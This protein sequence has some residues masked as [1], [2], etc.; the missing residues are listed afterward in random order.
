MTRDG[1]R[2]INLTPRDCFPCAMCGTE[3][4]HRYAVPWYE[5][6]VLEGQNEGGYRSVCRKCSLHYDTAV[7]K[8]TA[9][10]VASWDNWKPSR[11]I[12]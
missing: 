12:A 10:V 3:G 2:V 5:G 8:A 11:D 4:D 7:A 1:V 9:N 6:P